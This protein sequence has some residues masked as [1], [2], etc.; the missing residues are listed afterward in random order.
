[1]ASPDRFVMFIVLTFELRALAFWLA[2][3]SDERG[4]LSFQ[5]EIKPPE[6]GRFHSIARG[7]N[8]PEL[9]IAA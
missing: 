7:V 5:W 1:M 9:H 3:K 4:R 2:K 6:E 8:F